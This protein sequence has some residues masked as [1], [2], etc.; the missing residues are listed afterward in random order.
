MLPYHPINH[1][2]GHKFRKNSYWALRGVD[3]IIVCNYLLPF[4]H[5][6]TPTH[7][8]VIFISTLTS[9][10]MVGAGGNVGHVTCFGQ[11]N[12]S[13]SSVRHLKHMLQMRLF[14]SPA[15]LLFF[16]FFFS[17]PG[18][19]LVPNKGCSFSLDAAMKIHGTGRSLLP[20]A[21]TCGVTKKGAFVVV[22]HWGIL[23]SFYCSSK[24]D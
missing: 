5:K 14:V 18:V 6:R 4:P 22:S 10:P 8:W 13:G 9:Q 24:T 16:F 17:M 12:R 2:P 15:L 7:L 23:F 19:G 1:A 20:A 21:G 11:W 3:F